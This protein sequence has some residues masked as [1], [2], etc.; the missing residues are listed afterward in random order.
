M[1]MSRDEIIELNKTSGFGW[2][3]DVHTGGAVPIFAI[4]AGSDL[5]RGKMDNTDIPKKIQKLMIKDK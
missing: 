3:S 4:G 2:T 1:N 5:F